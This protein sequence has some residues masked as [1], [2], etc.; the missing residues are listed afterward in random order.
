VTVVINRPNANPD[1]ASTTGT[2]PVT[3]DVLAN[4]TDPHGSGQLVPASVTIKTQPLHGSASVDPA[5]GQITYTRTG[6]TSAPI[7][8]PT[9]SP[10]SPGPN[11]QPARSASGSRR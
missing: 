1:A 11:R 10:I 2:T 3:I 9:R 4:D 7:R 5:T 6:I 8:S